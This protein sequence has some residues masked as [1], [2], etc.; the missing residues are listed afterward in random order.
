MKMSIFTTLAKAK[1]DIEGVKG[2]N[3]VAVRLTIDELARL[4]LYP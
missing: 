1:L 3:L 4:R 2:S